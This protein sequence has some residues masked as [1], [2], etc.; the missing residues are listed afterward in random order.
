MTKFVKSLA[1]FIAGLQLASAKDGTTAPIPTVSNDTLAPVSL[2]P[3]NNAFDNLFAQ[4]RS[5]SSHRSHASHSSHYSG[6]GG[7]STY[8]PP[9][10]AA[11]Y[12]PPEPAPAPPPPAK[13]GPVEEPK[14]LGQGSNTNSTPVPSSQTTKNSLL[15]P[16]NQSGGLETME[17]PMSR[18]E[19]LRLQIIRVQ[20]RLNS[21]GLYNGQIDGTFNTET[22]NALRLFQKVKSLPADGLMTTPTMN[23]LA[24]PTVQ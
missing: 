19:K 8:T 22:R 12:V 6:S 3:L 13:P 10:P 18:E 1:L 4:H 16:S 14:L 17:V 24:I 11:A 21:L 15:Q 20:I 5:H 9:R 7:T 23:A 2:R